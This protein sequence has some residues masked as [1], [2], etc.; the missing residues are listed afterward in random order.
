M[1]VTMLHVG[2][3]GEAVAMV[4]VKVERKETKRR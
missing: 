3:S 2:M 1:G 4:R